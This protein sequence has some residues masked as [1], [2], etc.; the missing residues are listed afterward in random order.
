MKILLVE[1][2]EP[3][4]L[5]LKEALSTHHYIVTLATDG[6]TGLELAQAYTY[7][8]LLLDVL[9]PKMNGMTLCR[10]L[11]SEGYQSPILL[12]TALDNSTDRVMGLDAGAD[13]YLVKPFDIEELMARIRALLRR[14]NS[15]LP[16]VL[17]WGELQFDPGASEFSYAGKILRLSAKEYSLLELFILNP[18][19]VFSR[20]AMIDRLWSD[21][22]YPEEN[23]VT[24]H[25]KTLR[26]K[27]K[28]VGAT[29]DFIETMY[30]LGYRLK[31]L[32]EKEVPV[33]ETLSTSNRAE[34]ARE[35]GEEKELPQQQ[36]KSSVS[37]LWEKF[38]GTFTA[39]VEVLEHA[40]QALTE[41]RL[42]VELQQKALQEAHRLGGSLGIFGFAEGS[43]L[44][45][46]LEQ[47]LEPEATIGQEQALQISK[48]LGLLQ[49]EL[50]KPPSESA[51]KSAPASNSASSSSRLL[52]ID[53]DVALTERLK[54][55]AT[56]WNML[57]DVAPS[58]KAARIAIA[59]TPPDIILLDLTFP[60]PTENGLT[61]L[62]ELAHQ[63][64]QIPVVA[65]TGRDSLSDR[66]EVARLGGRAFLHKPVSTEQ[67]FQ[68]LTQVLNR[69]RAVEAKVM[70]VDDDPIILATLSS[71]LKPWGLDVTT[72][73]NPQRFWEVLS[74]V[75]PDLL[76]LDLEM[77][78]FSGIE[79]CQVV[80]NDPQWSELPILFLTAHTEKDTINQAFAAGA[81][82]YI[83]KPIAEQEL[84]T[85]IVNRLER[86][87]WR[88]NEV[89]ES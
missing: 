62:A 54:G 47:L 37:K 29:S 53:D 49:Q 45:K 46:R 66:I 61:L 3:T 22:E 25:I 82:D 31:S 5:V 11:R 12:L 34:G 48:L 33:H 13:D 52:V 9:V 39:Q 80:R 35:A 44:A 88:Q 38:K 30:G 23:T 69:V 50:S 41:G 72:L 17:S 65:F 42:T 84:V 6:Q 4:A 18:R 68:T 55:E 32:P 58:L 16:P 73:E 27:L 83:S 78:R 60:T 43:K 36:V 14:G 71:L 7:D 67:I 28:A 79:L 21:E 75:A 74:Y 20:S 24:A 64:P 63:P 8:L 10:Q 19:R 87:R 1:D 85:R 76:V 56:A 57:L 86:V 15:T 2:D 40:T 81:D 26:K 89:S 70:V 77:P 59:S 51:S